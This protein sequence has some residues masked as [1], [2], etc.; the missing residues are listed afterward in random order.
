MSE[1]SGAAAPE[2][3]GL[4][5]EEGSRAALATGEMATS[6]SGGVG[7]LLRAAREDRKMSVAEAAQALKLGPRQVE[8]IEAEDWAALPGNTMIRGFVRN[9]A[10]LLNIDADLLMR[11]LD[12]VQLQ[13]T[14]HLD[15]S[16]GTSSSL[17][18]PAGRRVERRD[19][20]AIMA[21]LLLLALAAL[22]YFF[23]PL[24]SWQEKA[25]ALFARN[26]APAPVEVS[27]PAPAVATA[28][29]TGESVTV[30]A[31]PNA[32]V[33]S[34]AATGGQGLKF[35]F[36][37]PA[38]VEVRDGR[39][40]IILSELGQVGSQRTIDGQPPFSLVVG[41]SAYVTVEY[42]GKVIDLSQRS[43]GDVARITL[44]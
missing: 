6:L 18:N 37:R 15:V 26:T 2:V 8:A 1:A 34:E 11:R 14:A 19:Y 16:A 3:D 38:W 28:A 13:Q 27:A 29:A 31:T 7:Q 25:T 5:G 23:A 30:V 41:N 20:I 32:T 43:K 21:G 42:R 4:A 40:Q 12:A 36:A 39:G 17:P 9:Y 22:A 33:L 10:R 24:D 35:S 44:E